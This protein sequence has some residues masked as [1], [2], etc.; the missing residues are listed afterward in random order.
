MSDLE[1]R[2]ARSDDLALLTQALGQSYFFADRLA[3]QQDHRGVLFTAWKSGRPRGDV[4]L[5]LEPAEESEIRRYLPGVPFL[6]HVEVLE[7]YRNRGIGTRLIRAAERYLR[8]LGHR[9][10]GLAVEVSNTGAARLYRRL[11]YHR[12][13]FAPV[14]CYSLLGATGTVRLA[15]R[16]DVLVKPLSG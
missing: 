2:P 8:E 7:G 4:Y 12:W 1:I 5:R 9:R 15:E 16:C 3:C 14:L 13:E 11:G 10:V 6:T